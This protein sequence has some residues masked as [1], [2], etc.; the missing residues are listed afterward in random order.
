RPCRRPDRVRREQNHPVVQGCRQRVR[1]SGSRLRGPHHADAQR[2]VS[3][4]HIEGNGRLMM[5]RDAK[6]RCLWASRAAQALLFASCLLFYTVAR[7]EDDLPL[8]EETAMKAAVE[9]VAASVVRIE[10]LGGLETVGQMLVGTGPTTGLVVSS[11][12]YI[13]SSA[14]NFV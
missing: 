2:R 12:G 11:D 13:V 9:R 4:C 3:G 6:Y 1:P 10:T 14:F 8:R 7:A 5:P